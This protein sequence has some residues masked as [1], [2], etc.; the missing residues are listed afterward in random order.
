MFGAWGLGCRP[1]SFVLLL[2]YL[3]FA[4]KENQTA[5][6]LETE[7]DTVARGVDQSTSYI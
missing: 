2:G 1:S 5:K 3:N 6:K 4:T 7:T